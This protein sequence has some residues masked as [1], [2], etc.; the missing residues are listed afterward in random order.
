MHQNLIKLLKKQYQNLLL[1]YAR[2]IFIS[3]RVQ[4]W[5]HVPKARFNLIIHFSRK[6]KT[7]VPTLCLCMFTSAIYSYSYFLSSGMSTSSIVCSVNHTV[8]ITIANVTDINAFDESDW[9]IDGQAECEA[10]FMNTTV[11]HTNCRWLIALQYPKIRTLL[12]NMLSKIRAVV[13]GSN[14]IH[15]FDHVIN[16]VCGYVSNDTVTSSFIPLVNRGDI[17]SGMSRQL[18]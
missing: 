4:K 5:D 16:A 11:T 3:V 12:S 17:S 10:T 2:T 15:A 9:R 8:T 7:S 18:A 14:P 1:I 6:C 13:P